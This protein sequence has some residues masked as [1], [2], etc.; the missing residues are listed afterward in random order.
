MKNTMSFFSLFTSTA[1]LICCAI[2]ALLVVLGFGAT[3]ASVL[4]VFPQLIWLSENKLLVFVLSGFVIL[5]SHLLHRRTQTLD[6]PIDSKQDAC[7]TTKKSS[8]VILWMATI[9]WSI[10]FSFAYVIPNLL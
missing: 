2:P 4:S 9:L 10:G 7:V 8:K 6:C 1:T 5:S 3:L